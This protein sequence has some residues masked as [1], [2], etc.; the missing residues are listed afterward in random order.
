MPQK[1]VCALVFDFFSGE[2]YF[3]RPLYPKFSP[4]DFQILSPFAFHFSLAEIMNFKVSLCFWRRNSDFFSQAKNF[5]SRAEFCCFF[6]GLTFSSRAVFN[7]FLGQKIEN[8]LDRV[9]FFFSV[10]VLIGEG[11]CGK[12]PLKNETTKNKYRHIHTTHTHTPCAQTLFVLLRSVSR[13]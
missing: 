9:F 7:I 11:M 6:S 5:F 3:S 4:E 12:A 13:F 8:F 10:N 2:K 1:L